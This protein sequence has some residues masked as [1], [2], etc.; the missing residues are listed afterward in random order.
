MSNLADSD[1]DYMSS[2]YLTELPSSLTTKPK[3]YSEIRRQKLSSKSGYIK[4]LRER[5]KESREQ[6]LSK[7]IDEEDN[8]ESPGLRLLKKMGY[9]K[10]KPLGKDS[11]GITEPINI[12]MKSDKSGLGLSSELKQKAEKELTRKVKRAKINEDSFIERVRQGQVEKKVNAQL[13]K[14]QRVCETL[15]TRKGVMDNIFWPSKDDKDDEEID[16]EPSEFGKLSPEEKLDCVLKYMREEYNYCFWC[17][18]EYGDAEELEQLCPGI[19]EDDH[20]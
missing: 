3:T 19:N 11:S 2:K 20:D 4:P 18:C 12:E 10:G 15:D 5:E 8:A 9:E 17:G 13:S 7:R 6:G 14:A 16:E 1:D